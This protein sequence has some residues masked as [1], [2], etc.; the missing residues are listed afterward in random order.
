MKTI[1]KPAMLAMTAIFLAANTEAAVFSDLHIFS[2]NDGSYPTAKLLLYGHTLYGTTWFGG[3][4]GVG[5]GPNH[6]DGTVFAVNVDGTGFTNLYEFTTGGPYGGLVL[7]SNSATLYGTLTYATDGYGSIFAINTDGTDYTNFYGFNFFP[8]GANPYSGLILSGGILYGTTTVGG[9]NGSGSYGTVFAINTDGTDFTNLYNFNSGTRSQS[10]QPGLVLSGNTLYGVRTDGGSNDNGNVFAV[11]TDGTGF[12]NLYIFSATTYDS[13]SENASST[14][15]DGA[16]PYSVLV[17]SGNTLYGTTKRGGT[18]GEGTVFAI[19]T[20]GTGFT[21][22]YTFSAADYVGPSYFTNSD[23][24][25]PNAGLMLSSNTLYGTT[26][27]GGSGGSGT[28]FAINTNGTGFTN[29]YAFTAGSYVNN[30]LATLTINNEGA[31]P[32]ASLIL[33]DNTLYGTTFSGGTNAEGAVFALSLGPIPLNIQTISNAVVLNW[34]N[35]AFSLQAATNVSGIYANVPGA[36]SPYTNI[37]T[38]SQQF[39]RLQAN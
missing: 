2:G 21:N 34:G 13:S 36:T 29:L 39:F 7:S 19:N 3:T 9:I 15:S 35:P 4:N 18:N 5:N 38:G 10:F 30:P 8:D 17:L 27:F 26:E 25:A 16:V 6:G 37:I 20:D 23:G 1:L 32:W 33:S 31:T 14:N 12:T 28:V 11:N 22:L 24:F